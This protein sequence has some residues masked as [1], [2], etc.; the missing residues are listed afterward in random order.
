[1]IKSKQQINQPL[2]HKAALLRMDQECWLDG[3]QNRPLLRN[4][5]LEP[6]L[7]L[8]YLR[9]EET[10]C[11][12]WLCSLLSPWRTHKDRLPCHIFQLIL[13]WPAWL[14][15]PRQGL[16]CQG[17][18]HK[19]WATR[20][21]NGLNCRWQ[22]GSGVLHPSSEAWPV[23]L[24]HVFGWRPPRP[25]DEGLSE[26]FFRAHN[27]IEHIGISGSQQGP[28]CGTQVAVGRGASCR[29]TPAR[30]KPR[31]FEDC[32]GKIDKKIQFSSKIFTYTRSTTSSDC[33][34]QTRLP[35]GRKGTWGQAQPL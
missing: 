32:K 33:A 28:R 6:W 21:C 13:Q 30:S 34:G 23:G 10:S 8:W 9:E 2:S 19:S 20:L 18:T 22:E 12:K 24:L 5:H 11:P 26:N 3:S 4:S 29:G 25:Q 1:M 14:Y 31:M 35:V 15:R 27:N 7:L 17:S 16:L